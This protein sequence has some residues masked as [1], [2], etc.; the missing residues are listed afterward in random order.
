MKYANNYIKFKDQPAYIQLYIYI[1]AINLLCEVRF[2][3]HAEKYNSY[4]NKLTKLNS[5]LR[6]M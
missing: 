1:Y 6:E 3:K 5:E 2:Q 4:Q